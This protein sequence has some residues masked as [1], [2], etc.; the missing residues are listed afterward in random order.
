MSI[1]CDCEKCGRGIL[2]GDR[3]YSLTLSRDYIVSEKDVQPLE[4]E[5]IAMWCLDCGRSAV[6][7]FTDKVRAEILIT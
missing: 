4:A 2:A 6:S 3:C 1:F 7:S 5:S